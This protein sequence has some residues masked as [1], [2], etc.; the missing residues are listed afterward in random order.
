MFDNPNVG[1]AL[2]EM[3]GL[4]MTYY[5]PLRAGHMWGPITR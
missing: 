3:S 1:V 4:I 5:E 2:K